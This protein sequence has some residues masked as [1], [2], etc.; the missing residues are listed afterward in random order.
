MPQLRLPCP[1]ITSSPVLFL[2][3]H[4]P[5][6]SQCTPGMAVALVPQYE[7]PGMSM[8]LRPAWITGWDTV[9]EAHRNSKETHACNLSTGKLRQ[10]WGESESSLGYT[11]SSKSLRIACEILCHVPDRAVNS[12]LDRLEDPWL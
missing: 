9:L 3:K 2:G 4:L 7:D 8:N 1:V 6:K 5:Q 12:S 10:D 11:V